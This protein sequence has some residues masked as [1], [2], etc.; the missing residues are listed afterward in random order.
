M[1]HILV[2]ERNILKVP[3]FHKNAM[4]SLEVLKIQMKVKMCSETAR[5]PERED[6]YGAVVITGSWKNRIIKL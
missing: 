5:I 4:L 6:V 1:G 3:D 2:I